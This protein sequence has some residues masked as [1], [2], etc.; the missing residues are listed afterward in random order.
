MPAGIHIDPS[1]RIWIADSYNRR[2][3]VFQYLPEA[4]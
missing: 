4:E 2:V 3:Q 1:D